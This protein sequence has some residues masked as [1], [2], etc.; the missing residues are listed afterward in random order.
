MIKSSLLWAKKVL[1]SYDKIKYTHQKSQGKSPAPLIKISVLE[2]FVANRLVFRY[3]QKKVTAPR[4]PGSIRVKMLGGGGGDFPPPG[5]LGD[6][7][8]ILYD[9]ENYFGGS[10]AIL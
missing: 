6:E 5:F 4:K 3:C 9:H 8:K 2:D 7:L 10:N 1:E